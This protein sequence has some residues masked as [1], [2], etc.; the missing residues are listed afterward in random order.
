MPLILAFLVALLGV[1]VIYHLMNRIPVLPHGAG[2]W[3]AKGT[4]DPRIATAAMLCAV[5]AEDGPLTAAEKQQISSLL[6]AKIGLEP[7][8]AAKCQTAGSRL[9]RRVRGDLNSRLHQLRGPIEKSCSQQE[10]QDVVDMLHTVAGR[11]A[12]RLPSVREGLGRV[13]A[14]L[15]NG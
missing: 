13:S 11:T 2:E 6:T 1:A 7:A 9:A 4:D 12:E 10:K 14:S 8:T 5:A 15:L 3:G